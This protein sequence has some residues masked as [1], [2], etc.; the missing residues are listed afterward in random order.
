MERKA[1]VEL[2]SSHQLQLGIILGALCF[3]NCHAPYRT[4]LIFL[5]EYVLWNIESVF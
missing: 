3:L 4:A 1:Y 5:K 2:L